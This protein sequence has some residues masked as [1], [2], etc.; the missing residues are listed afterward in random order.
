[1]SLDEATR[2]AFTV[3]EVGDFIL[4]RPTPKD[5]RAIAVK[6]RQYLRQD[7]PEY[8][9]AANVAPIPLSAMSSDLCYA[10]ALIDTLAEA[11][12]LD[13][14]FD[15]VYNVRGLVAMIA[16]WEKWVDSFP[17]GFE[18]AKPADGLGGH[19][20]KTDGATGGG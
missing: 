3:P 7:D 19:P 9:R 17:S 20:D 11:K 8:D 10:H 2:K 5:Y 14:D 6:Q 16:E 4:K 18:P 12:P 15:A 1:M 13:F